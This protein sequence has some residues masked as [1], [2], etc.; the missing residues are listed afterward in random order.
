[1]GTNVQASAQQSNLEPDLDERA[2][3]RQAIG[4][5]AH[6]PTAKKE[7]YR[8]PDEEQPNGFLW[9]ALVLF[10]ILAV[11]A[12]AVAWSIFTTGSWQ[13][14]FTRMVPSFREENLVVDD[15]FNP[16]VLDLV[17][18][19][20]PGQWSLGFEQGVYRIR[21]E[22]PGQLLWSTLGMLRLGPNRFE[23]EVSVDRETPWG[24]A[25]LI[26]RYQNDENFYLFS[27]DGQG[28]FQIQLLKDGAWN[29]LKPWTAS[30]ALHKDGKRN[31]LAV[32]DDGSQLRFF[33][34]GEE[35]DR[36]R[37]IRLQPGDLGLA[38]GTRSQGTAVVTYERVRVY[39]TPVR[40]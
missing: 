33:G 1:M 30:K 34:N 6:R 27:V 20:T 40:K 37:K 21:I 19:R 38:G 36:V 7:V 35:L 13:P 5:S 26:T 18:T 11:A 8:P 3:K 24:Y 15:S 17:Q 4:L 14:S 32:E 2:R 25:G 31:V 22:Q 28:A 29:T 10:L 9:I 39:E 12:A 16:P 23:V